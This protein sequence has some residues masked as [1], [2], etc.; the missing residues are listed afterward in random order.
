MAKRRQPM[1]FLFIRTEEWGKREDHVA[2]KRSLEGGKAKVSECDTVQQRIPPLLGSH[3]L[4][5][6][7]RSSFLHLPFNKRVKRGGRGAAGG[8][9]W[10][11]LTFLSVELHFNWLTAQDR[12][13]SKHLTSLTTLELIFYYSSK[14]LKPQLWVWNRFIIDV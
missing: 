2:L 7:R 1:E 11:R 13:F 9:S 8:G 4:D 3:V 6:Y 5:A 12:G 10:A 14:I